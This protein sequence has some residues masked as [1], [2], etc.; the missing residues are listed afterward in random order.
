MNNKKKLIFISDESMEC[1]YKNIDKDV[2]ILPSMTEGNCVYYSPQKDSSF[3]FSSCYLGDVINFYENSALPQDSTLKDYLLS[4]EEESVACPFEMKEIDTEDRAVILLTQKCNLACSYCFAQ[5]SRSKDV[6]P[7][8]KVYAVVDH[9]FSFNNNKSKAFSFLGGGEPLICWNTIQRAAEYIQQ[10]SKEMHIPY[11][12]SVVTNA[13]LLTEEKVKWIAQHGVIVSVSSD[14]LP[15]IQ[16]A[17]RPYA[18]KKDYS[19]DHV[20]LAI[21][22]LLKYH[23]PFKL[24]ATITDM[25]V[26]RMQEMVDFVHNNYPSLK[27]MHLEPVTDSAED[28]E[29]FYSQYVENFFAAYKLGQCFGIKVTNSLYSSFYHIKQHF[30]QGELCVTP[31]GDIVSCHR[32]SS[33]NDEYYDACRYGVV[34]GK[35]QIDRELLRNV[36]TMRQ[37]RIVDCNECF[38]KWHCAGGCASQKMVFTKEQQLSFCNYVRTF[39]RNLLELE[40]KNNN[41]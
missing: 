17:Q 12:L 3:E 20:D 32:H 18:F 28:Y 22:L 16:N 24:R 21:K 1:L 33:T 2:Y 31:S 13:T 39:I 14:I 15:D 29:A 38:A 5:S 19:F 9:M 37:Q 23:V 41:Q 8:D 7:L 36:I 4:I 11:R 26:K 30:C 34:N 10:K 27:V 25:N 35:V 6:L 40:I